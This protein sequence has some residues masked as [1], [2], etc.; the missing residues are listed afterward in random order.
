MVFTR[1]SI[2]LAGAGMLAVI[3]PVTIWC[4]G[5]PLAVAVPGVFAYHVLTLW[6]PTPL[7]LATLRTLRE[8]MARPGSARKSWAEEL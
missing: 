4:S 6:L 3:L 1:R 7:S 5:A 8:L 2:P